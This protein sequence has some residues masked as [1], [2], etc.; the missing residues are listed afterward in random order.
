MGTSNRK[1][2][3]FHSAKN[4]LAKDFI[5]L[6]PNRWPQKSDIWSV[7]PK[8]VSTQHLLITM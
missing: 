4:V 6:Q 7:E 3:I 8:L 2:N 1:V 5:F